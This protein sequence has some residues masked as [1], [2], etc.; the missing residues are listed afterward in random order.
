MQQDDAA[1][2]A[3]SKKGDLPAFN[4]IVERYQ[5]QVYS[6]AARIVGDLTTAED[7]SQETFVSAHRALSKFR[8]GSLRAWL[9]RIASNLSYD[10]L[11]ST[12]RRPET[13]LDESMEN[14]SFSLPSKDPSPER[15]AELG[16]LRSEIEKAIASLPDDQRATLVLID[17]QGFSYEEASEATGANMGTV[18]SRLSRARR[19]V[20]DY[21]KDHTELLPDRFRQSN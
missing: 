6:V 2:V 7:I 8:G 18:K 11:R 16:E 15:V 5:S 14:P 3:L 20:R 12:K 1:L 9:L 10:F 19:G 17:V 13:S 4:Q 21:L